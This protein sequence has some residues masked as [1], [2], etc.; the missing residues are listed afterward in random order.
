MTDN[1][2]ALAVRPEQTEWTE[3][4]LAV[5]R[6]TGIDQDISR[7]ELQ[8]FLH[9][10]QRRGLDPFARQ[11]YLIGRYDR[12]AG[13]KIYRPQT[14]IDGMRLVA[15]RATDQA[16]ETL[17]YEDTIWFD[18]T[19][20]EHHVWLSSDAPAAAKVVVRRNGGRF[21]AIARYDAYVQLDRSGKPAGLWPKMPDLLLEKAAESAALRKA[22]PEDLS[23]LYT[24]TEMDQ[25]DNHQPQ[26]T[27][28]VATKPA[29]PED[30]SEYQDA[31]WIADTVAEEQHRGTLTI[32]VLRTFWKRAHQF[33]CMGYHVTHP[34]TGDTVPLSQLLTATANSLPVGEQLGEDGSDEQMDAADQETVEENQE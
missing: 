8:T 2:S 9:T 30:A 31:Q 22:C 14:S 32:D 27:A 5:L 34:M 15:R 13:R 20:R 33:G 6:Q 11:I 17:S 4:Q 24:D 21:P 3:A 18:T 7:E 29:E 26:P 1:T 28:Q 16:G 23:G 25:A 10:C 12:Q 19:G